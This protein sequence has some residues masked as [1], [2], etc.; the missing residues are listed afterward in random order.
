MRLD[1]NGFAILSE[2]TKDF[3]LKRHLRDA[4]LPVKYDDL[5]LEDFSLNQDAFGKDL[6]QEDVKKKKKA[7]EVVINYI[8]ALPQVLDGKPMR[9]QSTNGAELSALDLFFYGGPASGKTM[10]LALILKESL[11]FSKQVMYLDWSPLVGGVL[12]RYDKKEQIDNLINMFKT[13]DMLAIDNIAPGAMGEFAQRNLDIL[14]SER[15]NVNKPTLFG[16]YVAPQAVGSI[17]G[18]SAQRYLMDT[19]IVNLPSA[20]NE[21]FLTVN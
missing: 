10:L 4:R 17:W 14:L 2:Q 9:I 5:S 16:S 3:F 7:K 1:E 19:L 11:R 8:D 15:D 12:S 6:S 18:M 20:Q 21:E 13:Y